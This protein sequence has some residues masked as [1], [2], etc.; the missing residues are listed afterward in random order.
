M[1]SPRPAGLSL[2]ESDPK[3]HVSDA[4]SVSRLWVACNDIFDLVGGQG[5]L[6]DTFQPRLTAA[7]SSPFLE[8]PYT[9]D[10]KPSPAAK[11][12]DRIY[13]TCT[14]IHMSAFFL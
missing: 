14:R 4:E 8:K 6:T 11:V 1:S 10:D 3:E 7:A 9:S 2:V 12:R 13:H 5:S